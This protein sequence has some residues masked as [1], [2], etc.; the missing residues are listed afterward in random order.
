[1]RFT[2]KIYFKLH[3]CKV[4]N[5]YLFSYVEENQRKVKAHCSYTI[6]RNIRNEVGRIQVCNI[7]AFTFQIQVLCTP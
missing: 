2:D 5:V 7:F 6:D 3:I 1:M 4:K